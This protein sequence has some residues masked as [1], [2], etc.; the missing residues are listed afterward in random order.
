MSLKYC[1]LSGGV[2][3]HPEVGLGRVLLPTEVWHHPHEALE[4]LG[5]EVGQYGHTTTQPFSH[6]FSRL[7]SN[8]NR[9]CT[10]MNQSRSG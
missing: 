7:T 2:G 4:S 10:I 9:L 6:N 1:R 5:E 8:Q 3:P